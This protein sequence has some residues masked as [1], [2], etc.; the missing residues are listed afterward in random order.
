MNRLIVLI[1]LFALGLSACV[2][3]GPA[4]NLEQVPP[5]KLYE[6]S[7]IN[8]KA[9]NAE[10]WYLVESS[11]TGMAFARSGDSVNESF[12]A[13]VAMF[14]FPQTN[15]PE[16]FEALIVDRASRD[17]E[18][19]RFTTRKFSHEYTD[20]RGYPC[21]R[22]HNVSVDNNPQTSS[23]NAKNLF[24]ENVHLYCRHPVRTDTGFVISYSHRGE[25]LYS[26]LKSE[27]EA[28]IQGVWVPDSSN[29]PTQ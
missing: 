7:Y 22:A 24:L 6:G 20:T 28:F 5:G 9:P 1:S 4:R 3:P 8:I 17:L 26:N 10:G 25:S 21:V 29:P 18:T 15:S 2:A 11:N 14:N 27:A 23:G 19:D 13:Q 12:A 16:E